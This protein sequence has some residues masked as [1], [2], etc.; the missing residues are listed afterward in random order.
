MRKP[1]ER[2]KLITLERPCAF[3]RKGRINHMI[4][5]EEKA[6][7]ENVEERILEAGG[8]AQPS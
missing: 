3:L 6:V 5:L 7:K 1:L 2:N 4:I 8:E